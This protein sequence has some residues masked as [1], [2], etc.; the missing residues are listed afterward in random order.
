MLG[1]RLAVALFELWAM[2]GYVSEGRRWL[3][4]LL[5]RIPERSSVRATALW[6]VGNLALMQHDPASALTP[7]QES[8]A[9]GRELGDE[10]ATVSALIGL[11][12]VALRQH[13][14]MR[15]AQL[16]AE[17]LALSRKLGDTYTIAFALHQS[18]KVAQAQGDFE[19]AVALVTE[20]LALH[21]R[22]GDQLGVAG[23]LLRLGQV[24]YAQADIAQAQA[25]FEESLAI[26]R[27]LGN[28]IAIPLILLGEVARATSL[29]SESLSLSRKCGDREGIALCLADSAGVAIARKQL[30]LAVRLFG[31]VGRLLRKMNARLDL[32]G[33]L[34]HNRNLAAARTQT[35]A[36]TFAEA[37]AQGRDL[38]LEQALAEALAV[39]EA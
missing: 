13:D 6:Q 23:S 28:N 33:R 17:G 26:Q 27:R 16:F 11:G 36:Q 19:Q 22:M 14:V 2:R 31:L 5:V 39:V 18:S 37:W 12:I 34:E 32:A 10:H 38:P 9:I 29:F 4:D 24:S 1:A 7:L 8:L 21:R 15:S 30:V 35:D 20:S 25:F 3:N